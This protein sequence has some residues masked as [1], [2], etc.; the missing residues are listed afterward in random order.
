MS[1]HQDGERVARQCTYSLESMFGWVMADDGEEIES[2]P[3]TLPV[4]CAQ[5]RRG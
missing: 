1:Q 2:D 5:R 3:L 4:F